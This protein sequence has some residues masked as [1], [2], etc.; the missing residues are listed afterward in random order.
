MDSVS[1]IKFIRAGQ[2]VRGFPCGKSPNK[3]VNL[4][5]RNCSP[6][7]RPDLILQILN[8]T[9]TTEDAGLFVGVKLTGGGCYDCLFT[10]VTDD[11]RPEHLLTEKHF[12][13]FSEEEQ[14]R[15]HCSKHYSL[16][17][18]LAVWS[19]LKIGGR[20][21]FYESLPAA[22]VEERDSFLHEDDLDFIAEMW[23]VKVIA[24]DTYSKKNKFWPVWENSPGFAR[25]E[26]GAWTLHPTAFANLLFPGGTIPLT[27]PYTPDEFL[28]ADQMWAA[29][30]AII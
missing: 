9:E 3:A 18:Y 11:C 16:S 14:R 4:V 8:G 25:W 15:L 7:F 21:S 12:S 23:Q 26:G 19:A 24:R 20:T 1:L 27:M 5:A 6:A 13:L 17:S 29:L 30:K 28:P 2:S 22:D 10:E